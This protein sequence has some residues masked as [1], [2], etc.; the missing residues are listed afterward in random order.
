MKELDIENKLPHPSVKLK[1]N[2]ILDEF[3]NSLAFKYSVESEKRFLEAMKYAFRYQMSKSAFLKKYFKIIDFSLDSIKR[4]ED[5][6]KFPFIFVNGFKERLLTTLKPSEI[7]LELKSSGTSGQVSRMQL[8]KGSLMRV[9]HMAWNIFNELGL[10]DLDNEYDYLC[11]TYDPNIAKD[12][13]TAWTDKLLTSFTKAGDIFYAFKWDENKKEFYFDIEKSLEKLLELERTNK[14]ARL[15]GFPAFALK[16]TE[17]FKKRFKRY[18]KLNPDS[19]VITGGG[20]KTLSD[21]AIDKNIYRHILAENLSIS[22]E[23]IRDLFGMVEHGVA[24]VD[25]K[26]GNFHIPVYGKIIARDPISF[27]NLGYGKTGLLQFMTPYLTSYPSISILSSDWG[28]LKESCPCGLP[29][30][31]LFLK[32]RA[33]VKKLKGCAINAAQMLK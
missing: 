12:V 25:C 6:D 2:N 20:W 18:P 16:L 17:E 14:R 33:G 24:Y 15:I 7:V 10:C 19:F 5:V 11:F 4:K 13:G 9:R 32:G 30:P 8:D 22:V 31:V 1:E 28:Y 21:E 23:H 27:E 3:I 26:L 29:G